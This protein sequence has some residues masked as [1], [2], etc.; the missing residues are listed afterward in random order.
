MKHAS[1]AAGK[2]SG[3]SGVALSLQWISRTIATGNSSGT[4]N[5]ARS[6]SMRSAPSSSYVQKE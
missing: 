4:E 1:A 5:A 3:R 6:E 2:D